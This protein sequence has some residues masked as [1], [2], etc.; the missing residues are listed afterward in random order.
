M[1][2][3]TAVPEVSDTISKPDG[4]GVQMRRVGIDC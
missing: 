1:K 2:S 3:F 4:A